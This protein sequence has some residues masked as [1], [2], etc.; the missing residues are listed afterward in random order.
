MQWANRSMRNDTRSRSCVSWPNS[1]RAEQE[2][3]EAINWM[4][5]THAQAADLLHIPV[6]TV[7]SRLARAHR[8]L[9]SLVASSAPA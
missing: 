9:R 4:G 5:L 8:K 6:G 2:A 1:H 7:K 3:I